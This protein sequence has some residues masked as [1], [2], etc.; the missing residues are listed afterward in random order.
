M[1]IDSSMVTLASQQSLVQEYQKTEELNVQAGR[2]LPPVSSTPG[3]DRVSISDKAMQHLEKDLAKAMKHL[4]K[5]MNRAG[6][7]REKV[8]RK[9]MKHLAKDLDRAIRHLEKHIEKADD[10]DT[11]EVKE[12]SVNSHDASKSGLVKNLLEALIGSGVRLHGMEESERHREHGHHHHGRDDDDE[13]HDHD[14]KDMASKRNWSLEYKSQETYYE[15]Q[16]M[17]FNAGGI[18]N[19]AD[20]REINFSLDLMMAREFMTVNNISLKA[21]AVA[22][23]NLIVDFDGPASELASTEFQF[24]MD[25][26]EDRETVSYL[27]LGGGLLSMD[28]DND[29]TINALSEVIGTETG[30][31]FA[32]LS[33]YDLDGNGWIDEN[34]TVFDQLQILSQDTNGNDVATG[35][36]ENNVGAIYLSSVHSPYELKNDGNVLLGQIEESGVYLGEDGTPGTVQQLSMLV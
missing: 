1:I 33:A 22:G 4:E 25:P 9:A 7:D 14:R 15:N 34:D 31:G 21:G 23:Q 3:A 16:Q 29:G 10:Q 17:T 5:H 2:E 13:G 32:E 18:V 35:L 36:R 8:Y 28:F 30:N 12:I 11:E 20:G 27:S 26:D 19:T 24:G 6:E